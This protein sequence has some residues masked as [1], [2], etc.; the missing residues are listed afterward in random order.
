MLL[1]DTIILSAN[2]IKKKLG[3]PHLRL[4]AK[5][6]KN[7]KKWKISFLDNIK[8]SYIEKDQVF[9][10]EMTR[11]IQNCIVVQWILGIPVRKRNLRICDDGNSQ[12]IVSID[13][14]IDYS[15]IEIP[16][17]IIKNWFF[18]SWD[19]FLEKIYE[20]FKDV[21]TKICDMCRDIITRHSPEQIWWIK[22]ILS[23]LDDN[24]I[25]KNDF[26]CRKN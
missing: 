1:D 17:T 6:K 16:S 2:S 11:D 24:F 12:R 23:R 3:L 13:R 19:F 22:Q 10:E 25:V 21:K 26:V 4:H 18:N 15:I 14:K 20:I 5:K 8:L 9:T 7:S